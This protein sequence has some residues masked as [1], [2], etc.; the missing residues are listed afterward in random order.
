MLFRSRPTQININQQDPPLL[1]PSNPNTNN[2]LPVEL[3][4]SSNNNNNNNSRDNTPRT[5]MINLIQTN[6]N[7]QIS[8]SPT[9]TMSSP[10]FGPIYNTDGNLLAAPRMGKQRQGLVKN[11]F[12]SMLDLKTNHLNNKNNNNNNL[13]NSGYRD[14]LSSHGSLSRPSSQNSLFNGLLPSSFRTGSK[15][16]TSN[17]NI[18]SS[19]ASTSTNIINESNNTSSSTKQPRKSGGLFNRLSFGRNRASSGGFVTNNHHT[20]LK[21]NNNVPRTGSTLAFVHTSA[22]GLDF[23]E[24]DGVPIRSSTA[25]PSHDMEESKES[26]SETNGGSGAGDI[27]ADSSRR[28]SEEYLG[29]HSVHDIDAALRITSLNSSTSTGTSTMS[30]LTNHTLKTVEE[31]IGKNNNNVAITNITTNIGDQSLPAPPPPPPNYSTSATPGDSSTSIATTSTTST[32]NNT[33]PT[34]SNNNT[35][36]S[37]SPT[38]QDDTMTVLQNR[39]GNRQVVESVIRIHDIIQEIL[40]GQRITFAPSDKKTKDDLPA[41]SIE[42]CQAFYGIKMPKIKIDRYIARI[43]RYLDAYL[44]EKTC[45][46]ATGFLTVVYG[47]CLIDRLIIHK[48]LVLDSMNVHRV[49]MCMVLLAHKILEDEPCTNQY[50]A[51]V[52]GVDLQELNRL[53]GIALDLMDFFI[54]FIPTEMQKMYVLCNSEDIHHTVLPSWFLNEFLPS[55]HHDDGKEKDKVN[56]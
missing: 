35:S 18:S 42:T 13:E 16:T 34:T 39:L 33:D 3:G 41:L 23:H 36:S 15:S 31:S 10:T 53:E 30:L 12:G 51:N 25:P 43:I 20:N 50:F 21:H 54:P 47:L 19:S 24:D 44:E 22:H 27:T 56:D 1:N 17:K 46:Y 7:S 32:S 49:I 9:S 28:G 6:N 26:I 2:I 5:S 29:V 14:S 48:G 45:E 40:N 38:P 55:N 37:T 52:G 11:F 8:L 4:S